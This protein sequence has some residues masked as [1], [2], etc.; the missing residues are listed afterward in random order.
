MASADQAEINIGMIGHVDHGKTTLTRALSGIWTDKHSEEMKRGI[1]I[2]L[3]YADTTFRRC[4]ECDEPQC[5]TTSEVCDLC[6]TETKALRKVSFVDAPGH[7][8]LMATMLSGA[9]LMN[10]AVLV[11]AANEKCPQPQTREHLMAL[12]II[13]VKNIVIAQNK[14]ELVSREEALENYKQIKAFTKGTVAEAAPVIPISAQHAVNIDVL[15]KAIE[16]HIPTPPHDADAPAHMFVARSFD[17]NKPGAMPENIVGGVLG[18]SLTDG[19]I[20]VGQEI[21]ILPGLLT[22]EQGVSQFRPLV[23]KVASLSTG[24]LKLET[25]MP[26]GLLAIGTELDPSITKSDALGGCVVGDPGTLPPVWETIQLEIHLLERVVGSEEETAVTDIKRGEPL[27]LNVGTG[28]TIGVVAATGKK[29]RLNLKLPVCSSVGDRVAIS[30]R[31]GGRWRLIGY[32][33]ITE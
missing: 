20:T 9:A 3:G 17:I 33:I 30:R 12:D 19:R 16:D 7:E 11:I 28:K 10:G 4:T 29:A 21:E 22:K 14:I 25:A 26:G 31:I 2:R 27:M 15:I 5:Y 32:G 18:G 23:T 6:G 1:T 24:A 13:G 8:T